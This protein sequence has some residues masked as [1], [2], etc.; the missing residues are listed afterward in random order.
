MPQLSG[1]Y[2]AAKG[3]SKRR[4]PAT[5]R[6]RTLPRA[7]RVRY[8]TSKRPCPRVRK[9]RVVAGQRGAP[10]GEW[11]T[12]YRQHSGVSASQNDPMPAAGTN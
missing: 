8:G 11:F 12:R 1:L 3:P 10:F 2:R 4:D 6:R 7:A 9:T 5:A